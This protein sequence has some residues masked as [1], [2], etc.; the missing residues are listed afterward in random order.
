V[1]SS[2]SVTS[3]VRIVTVDST[4]HRLVRLDCKHDSSYK[5][6]GP[7][8]PGRYAPPDRAGHEL[9]QTKHPAREPE[10]QPDQPAGHYEAQGRIVYLPPPHHLWAW[11]KRGKFD[12]EDRCEGLFDSID[13]LPRFSMRWTVRRLRPESS[14]SCS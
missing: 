4:A 8:E 10:Y 12:L 11:R 9:R 5:P 6:H 14:A 3:V 7:D 13:A 1:I 2:L